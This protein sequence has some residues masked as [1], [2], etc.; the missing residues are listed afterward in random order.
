MGGLKVQNETSSCC[1][2]RIHCF[3]DVSASLGQTFPPL[4]KGV[5]DAFFDY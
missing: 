4:E 3:N 5:V 2:L 1:T